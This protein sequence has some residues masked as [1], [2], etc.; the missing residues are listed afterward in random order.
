MAQWIRRPP[1]KRKI[2]GSS[3]PVGTHTFRHLLYIFEAIKDFGVFCGGKMNI[4]VLMGVMNIF[5]F[6]PAEAETSCVRYMA[7]GAWRQEGV[8]E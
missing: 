7:S 1:P 4:N 2:G 8:G 5:I 3:P 6:Q